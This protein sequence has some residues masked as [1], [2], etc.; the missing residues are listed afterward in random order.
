MFNIAKF[1]AWLE[2]NES[3]PFFI[4]IK[5]LY[6]CLFASMLFSAEAW[7][8]LSRVDN[9]LLKNERKAIKSCLGIKSGTSTELIYQEIN[10]ADII[11]II[12]DR[13]FKFAEKIKR[14]GRNEALVK[15][16]WE[17][18]MI[19]GQPTALRQ[20][21]EQICNNNAE[22]NSSKRR[23]KIES[24]EQSMCARPKKICG[25]HNV[26]IASRRRKF[27]VSK[28]KYLYCTRLF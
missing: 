18:C 17:M 20:Y 1:H 22:T 5:V 14:L 6:G 27:A 11:S 8:N 19:D 26:T 10:R 16:I 15:E 24:S 3:T 23:N 12:K 7:G 9:S 13:Q 25:L 28:L 21:Y 2:Y 4:K